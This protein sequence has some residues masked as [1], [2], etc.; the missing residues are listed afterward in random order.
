MRLSSGAGEAAAVVLLVP[1]LLHPAW[2]NGFPF[3]F[4]DTGA[5]IVQGMGRILVPE[6]AGAY[7]LFLSYAGGGISLWLV[8]LAQCLMLAFA[9]VTIARL[10]WPRLSLAG[11]LPIGGALSLFTALA[12]VGGQIEPDALAAI[13]VLTLY[14][15]AF[16]KRRL[17]AV[18]ALALG[19]VGAF[20]IAAHPSHLGLAAGL[21][22]CLAGL[23]LAWLRRSWLPRPDLAAPCLCLAAGIALILAA[24]Y[25][26]TKQIFLSRS[27]T[28]F[29]AARLIGDGVAKPVLDEICPRKAN[30]LCPYRDGFPDSADA[31]LWDRDTAFDALGRFH[32]PRADYRELVL[33]SLK[34]HPLTILGSGLWSSLR[35]FFMVRTGDGIAPVFWIRQ[36]GF[37]N[38]LPGQLPAYETSRQQ[39]GRIRFDAVNVVHVPLAFAALIG[40]ILALRA[41]VK[42]RNRRRMALFGF[43]LMGLIGNALVCGL[44]SGAHDRYQ[45]RIVWIAPLVLL[46]THG[47]MATRILPTRRES[48]K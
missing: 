30:R 43:V 19:G 36:S 9:I 20:A 26:L 41:A 48:V 29:F 33:E 32:G 15:L 37:A 12:W 3:L 45:A 35:Q 46:L 27:G 23:R 42:G 21:V 24:N 13:P 40:L 4:F 18:R 5:Y 25:A 34:R 22:L 44:F 8:A 16:F 31:Y 17:G 39:A 28:I 11:M 10:L 7:S 6:R 2:W 14:P 1:I 38:Y 47:Q